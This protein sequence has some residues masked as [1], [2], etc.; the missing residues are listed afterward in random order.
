MLFPPASPLHDFLVTTVPVVTSS[1]TLRVSWQTTRSVGMGISTRNVETRYLPFPGYHGPRG[2]LS[3]DAPRL[4][5]DDAE[6][7]EGRFHAERG[8]EVY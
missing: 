6:R 5:A 2:N 8:N 4:V 7:R 3:S 1:P